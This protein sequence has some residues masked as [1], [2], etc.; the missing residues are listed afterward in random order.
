MFPEDKNVLYVCD[1]VM[2]DNG[3]LYV[4]PELV[5]I[6]RDKVIPSAWLVAPN[7][8]EAE[9]LTSLKIT[10]LESCKQ[11]IKILHDS[12]PQFVVVTSV[13]IG[14]GDDEKMCV[15]M[16]EK[17]GKA[18]VV[19]TPVVRSERASFVSLRSSSFAIANSL[20]PLYQQQVPGSY[21]GTG[22]LF[23]S[24]ILAHMK[25]NDNNVCESLTKTVRTLY[26]VI[27]RTHDFHGGM[28]GELRI[29]QSKDIIESGGN[30]SEEG[31]AFVADE[32]YFKPTE[33]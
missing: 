14:E 20:N 12:G 24:L 3:K 31:E 28:A 2:G 19:E 16:S 1:P 6:Y 30:G 5:N 17:Y 13:K 21:T 9:T 4:S 10:D 26:C 25:L 33:I 27:K 18:W 7:S 15:V 8:F 23:T 32:R 22:D 11:A 29:I